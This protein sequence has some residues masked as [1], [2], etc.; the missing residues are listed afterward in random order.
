MKNDL[1]KRDSRV[2]WHP[3][4]QA[5]IAPAP[6]PVVSGKGVW[7]ELE[8][9]RKILDGISSWWV[10]IAVELAEKL[11]EILPPG[12]TRVFYSDNGSTAVEVALK[13]AYQYWLNRGE[14]RKTFVALE[15]AYH[16]DTFG[17][18]AA[19]DESSFTAPFKNL[20]FDVLR[21]DTCYP[22]RCQWQGCESKCNL[23]C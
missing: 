8:D 15:N 2:L 3:Y 14:E 23:N 21:A 9:G 10:N 4:T 1:I 7:L 6:L 22:H 5:K 13:M 18:M 19:S 16:G 20:L 12:L 11:I 17:A